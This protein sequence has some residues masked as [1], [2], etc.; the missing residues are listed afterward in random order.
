[1]FICRMKYHF[2]SMKDWKK[3]KEKPLSI[4][5]EENRAIILRDGRSLFWV[6]LSFGDKWNN[7]DRFISL[8]VCRMEQFG[9]I[10]KGA[11]VLSESTYSLL[12]F[13]FMVFKNLRQVDSRLYEF[14]VVLTEGN[15]NSYSAGQ[16]LDLMFFW[17]LVVSMWIIGVRMAFD[18]HLS[19]RV[20][21]LIE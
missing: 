17:M 9:G 13:I 1:M 18:D 21:R 3:Q 8:F 20:E 7:L 19:A 11:N 14:I 12:M 5:G 6:R 10:Y 15:V 16:P 2:Q 4:Y